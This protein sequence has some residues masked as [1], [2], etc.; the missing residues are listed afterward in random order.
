MAIST[1]KFENIKS[2]IQ[3]FIDEEM[4]ADEN[5]FDL[6]H[7]FAD[8]LPFLEEKRNKVREMGL[9]T[10][11]IPKN[12][13]GLGLSLY[14]L[15]QIYEI[16][17]QTFY[18]L[19][20]FNC[21][22]PDAGNME[23]LMEHGTEYQKENFLNPLVAGK[24]RSCFSMT[25]PDYAGSNPI[26]MGTTAIKDGSNYVINGHKWFTSSADGADFAIAMVITDP[27][28]PNPYMRASQI[29]I[30]TD[31]KGFNFIRNISVMGDEGDGWNAHAEIKY[32]N[33]IVPEKNVL[34]PV[35]AGF[36]IAQDRLG[37][38][39]IHH[40]MRWIGECE[41][42]FEMMCERAASRELSP[43]KPLALKQTVQN[44]I[45]ESRAEINASRL[46]V[47]DAAK[48]IDNEGAY[49]AKVEIS[50]IK[51]YVAQV[52]QNV[53]DRAIQVHGALGMTDD[54]P[55]ASLYRHERSARIYDGA[56]EVHKTRV[57]KEIMKKYLK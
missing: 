20:V 19:Y 48:K 3:Q 7:K 51:F 34:G 30:P 15:G 55:L 1:E 47:L 38:G 33:C 43:G 8:H 28:N 17:G 49:A 22:A 11:Q 4:I 16:L 18:G 5:S 53:L 9:F 24:A 27:E 29:I 54:T 45:A 25:E 44:W 37:P 2:K 10:P 23:I 50:T 32:E 36:K 52:L 42:A 12:H 31:T 35:G 26:M 41:K 14:Q 13:G 40:C 46:M 6:S 57:A 39:R 21:Q 56:D